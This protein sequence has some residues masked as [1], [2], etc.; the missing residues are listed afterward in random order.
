VNNA[1]TTALC[2]RL[3]AVDWDGDMERSRSRVALMGEF[4]RRSALWADALGSPRWPFFDIASLIDPSVRATDDLVARARTRTALQDAVVGDTVTWAL[5]FAALR[6]AAIP[7]PELPDPF[8]PLVVMYDRGG[9]FS[10]HTGL[11]IQVDVINIP[12]GDRA[13]RATRKPLLLNPVALDA[14]D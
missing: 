12:I 4:L 6:D 13:D 2:K 8:E 3:A 9:G 1:H 5:H 11:F 14:L 10:R 7:L